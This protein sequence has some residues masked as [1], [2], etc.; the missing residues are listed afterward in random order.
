M[1]FTVS[2]GRIVG[3]DILADRDRLRALD[4]SLLG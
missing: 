2:G 4:L 3:I 1:S